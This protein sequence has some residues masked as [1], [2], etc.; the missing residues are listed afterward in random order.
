MLIIVGIGHVFFVH[1]YL[2]LNKDRLLSCLRHP[3]ASVTFPFISSRMVFSSLADSFYS[4]VSSQSGFVAVNMELSGTTRQ[5]PSF[6][7]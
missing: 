5:V 1:A 2:Y 6:G 7:I 4:Y 3:F